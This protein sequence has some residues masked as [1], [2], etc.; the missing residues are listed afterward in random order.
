MK[1]KGGKPN[2]NARWSIAALANSNYHVNCEQWK[3]SNGKP[4]AVPENW[5]KWRKTIGQLMKTYARDCKSNEHEGQV[6]KEL[7][8]IEDNHGKPKKMKG[9]PLQTEKRKILGKKLWRNPN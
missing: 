3:E 6:M 1:V 9:T 7:R 8:K 2:Y 4:T 5:W